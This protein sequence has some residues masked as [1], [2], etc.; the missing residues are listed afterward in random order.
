MVG[1]VHCTTSPLTATLTGDMIAL[2]SDPFGPL[3][4]TFPSLTVTVTPFGMEI[5]CFP[6]RDKVVSPLL[7]F[8]QSPLLLQAWRR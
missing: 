2:V 6:I 4:P 3:T 1:T 5:G 7:F 8:P